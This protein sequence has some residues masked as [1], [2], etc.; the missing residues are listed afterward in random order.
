M[1]SA[2]QSQQ[3]PQEQGI[4]FSETQ[5]EFM[6]YTGKQA[7]LYGGFGGGK[8]RTGCER[9]Y[10]LNMKYPGNRGL[11]V[12]SKSSDVK[13]STIGQSMLEEVIPDSHIPDDP[14]KGHNQTQRVIRHRTGTTTRFGEPVMSEIHYH[15]LDSSGSNSNDGLPRKI[16]GM[17]FGWIFVDEATELSEQDWVQLLGRLRY[18]G[19]VVGDKKYTVPFRQIW[20]ATNPAGPNHWLHEKFFSEEAENDPDRG[21]F[22]L[23]AED[24]PGVPQDYVEDMKANY[25]GVYYERY[26]LGNWVGTSDAIYDDFDRRK[27]V[28]DLSGLQELDNGWEMSELDGIHHPIPPEDWKV[29]RSIDFG[30]PSPMVVQWWA[31]SP[32]D[33]FVMFREFYQSSTLVEDAAEMIKMYSEDLQVNQTFADPA[34]ASDRETLQRNGVSSSKAKKDVWNGIQ[35]VKGVLSKDKLYFYEDALVHRPDESLDEDKK[36]NRTVDEIPGYEWK[37]KAD[38]RPKKEADHGCDSMRYCIYSVLGSG[39]HVSEDFMEEMEKMFNDGGF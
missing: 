25:S 34:Q 31:K 28:R 27:H 8:T 1:S 7:L 30:Y 12:R 35:E 10:L 22:H 13:G 16:S 14:S 23:K 38:D 20:G 15:G 3:E 33:T 37:D 5:K 17:Q 39:G 29:F 21:T 9:G 4:S 6:N 2:Q 18:D 19:K 26:V 11:V 36:P 24:N 32:D